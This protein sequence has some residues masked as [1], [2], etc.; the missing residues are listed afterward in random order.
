M[1]LEIRSFIL[2]LRNSELTHQ[3]FDVHVK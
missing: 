3:I 1:G 2:M